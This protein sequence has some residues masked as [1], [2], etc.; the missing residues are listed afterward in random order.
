MTERFDQDA[1]AI[2]WILANVGRDLRVALPL[3]LGKPVTLIN[4]LV[5]RACDDHSI[6]LDI[7]TA[8]TL[9]RPSP[10]SDMERRFLEPALDRL[11]GAY[12]QV[13]YARLLREGKL[14]DNIQ[15]TE[16]F[17]QAANWLKVAPMQQNYVSANYTHA[18]DVLLSQRPNLVLQLLAGE[19]DRL[20]LSCNTDITGDLLALRRKGDADFAFVGQVHPDLPFM[21]GPAEMDAT[22]CAALVRTKEKPHDLFSLVKRPVGL[23]DHAIGLHASRLI[24][25]GGTL[26]IGI[27]EVGDAVAHAL[28][29][30]QRRQVTPIWEDCPFPQ[31]ESFTET[32]PFETGLYGVTE[33]LVDGM[34]ALFEEGVIRREV[35][36]AAIHAGFFLDSRDFYERLRALPEERRARIAMMPVSFTNALYGDEDAK[37][38][39]RVDA[40]FVN[41][42]MMVTL[43]GAAVS[44]G[45]EDG[46]VV[47]GVG[48]QFN[49]VDQAFALQGARAVLTLPATRQGKG[50]L[51]S[52]IRWNYGHITIPRHLRDIVV[53]EYGIADLRGKSDADTIAALIRIADSRFQEELAETAKSAGKLPESWR[54]PKAARNNTPETLRAW[55]APHEGDALPRFPFGTDFSGIEQVLLPALADLR[56][57][58]NRLPALM[59]LAIDGLRGP[60]APQEAEAMARMDLSGPAGWKTRLAASALRGALRRNA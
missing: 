38:T 44:D 7:F 45:T 22:E 5:R 18:L 56:T 55:L 53:T 25:D 52:N 40:R 47:S 27:G 42:A 31:G 8:L 39:A 19:G 32:G 3:G 1:A 43:L 13:E 4:E 37:R 10:S 35:D 23:R 9:E 58:S 33:M 49:F 20:S 29:L 34:L 17:L 26:Q 60:P 16:F 41:A 6:R 48:G 2:D 59:S 50:G 28:I 54:L 46:Q 24:P 36:G 11:F 30:R 14:P 21:P 15:V 12:P 57:A 51:S